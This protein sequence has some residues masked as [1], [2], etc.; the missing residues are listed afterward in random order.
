MNSPYPKFYNSRRSLSAHDRVC[1][2]S[3]IRSIGITALYPIFI[4]FDDNWFL[5]SSR[6]ISRNNRIFTFSKRDR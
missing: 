3:I 4:N 5:G 1:N 6:T 2:S